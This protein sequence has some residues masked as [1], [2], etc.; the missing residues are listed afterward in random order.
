MPELIIGKEYVLDGEVVTLTHEHGKMY[1]FSN[2]AVRMWS[3]L[4]GLYCQ[5]RFDSNGW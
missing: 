1:R 5:K 4:R 3:T 2:G